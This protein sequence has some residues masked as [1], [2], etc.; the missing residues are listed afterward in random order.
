MKVFKGFAPMYGAVVQDVSGLDEGRG[1]RL[2]VPIF[3]DAYQWEGKKVAPSGAAARVRL[4]VGPRDATW[5]DENAITYSEWWDG[6]NTADFYLQYS[7][8]VFDFAATEPEMTIY[9]ELAGIFGLSNNG[10]F[11]DDV[12][13]YPLGTRLATP[14]PAG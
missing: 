6:A 13:L 8:F 1:Y 14:T 7:D 2:I 4:G 12:R 9:I 3:V 11:L 5:R 10:F